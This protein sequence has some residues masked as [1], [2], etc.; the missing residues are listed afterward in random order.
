MS[1]WIQCFILHH[2]Y[3]HFSVRHIEWARSA[4]IEREALWGVILSL[5]FLKKNTENL[6]K[7]A[8]HRVVPTKSTFIW[9]PKFM[10][11]FYLKP[12]KIYL[13]FIRKIKFYLL[14]NEKKKYLSLKIL[15]ALSNL[16]NSEINFLLFY[17]SKNFSGKFYFLYHKIVLSSL[18]FGW[19]KNENKT[20]CK[21]K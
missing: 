14:E 19:Q 5:E 21:I 1:W 18:H 12:S 16:K 15:V 7:L 20:W 11:K 13:D 4:P 9:L 3:F 10:P 8:G 2:F 17:F 6:Q